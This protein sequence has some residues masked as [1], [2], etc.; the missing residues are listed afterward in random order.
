MNHS[1]DMR[2]TCERPAMYRLTLPVPFA[3]VRDLPSRLTQWVT[4]RMNLAGTGD[5]A[6]SFDASE[7]LTVQSRLLEWKLEGRHEDDG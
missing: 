5:S 1:G 7:V 4:L 2:V 3:V 6:E